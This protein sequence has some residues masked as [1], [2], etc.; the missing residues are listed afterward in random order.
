MGHMC[1]YKRMSASVHIL[2]ECLSDGKLY[3]YLIKNRL[4]ENSDR[5]FL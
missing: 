1:A 2:A 4:L 3:S 5:R